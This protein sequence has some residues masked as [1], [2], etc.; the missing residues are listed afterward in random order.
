VLF[1]SDWMHW[2]LYER[3]KGAKP[4]LAIVS[5]FVERRAMEDAETLGISVFSRLSLVS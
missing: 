1:N 3:V 2:E 5:P 4:S